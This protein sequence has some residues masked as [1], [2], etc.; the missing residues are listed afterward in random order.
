MCE[1]KTR[2]FFRPNGNLW[3]LYFVVKG[4]SSFSI[5]HIRQYVGSDAGAKRTL[6]FSAPPV[7]HAQDV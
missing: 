1:K 3:F 5:P 6:F 4:R 2:I 7:S